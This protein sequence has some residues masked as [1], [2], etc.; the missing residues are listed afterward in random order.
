LPEDNVAV[1]DDIFAL[2][3]GIVCNL[4][5]AVHGCE[6]G[7]GRCEKCLIQVLAKFVSKKGNEE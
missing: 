2:A 5:V 6:D 1:V 7:G 4:D 3:I